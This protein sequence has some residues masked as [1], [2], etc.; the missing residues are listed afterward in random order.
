MGREAIVSLLSESHGGHAWWWMWSDAPTDGLFKAGFT[1]A[2]IPYLGAQVG[3]FPVWQLASLFDTVPGE[4][5]DPGNGDR[6]DVF[7]QYLIGF[8]D[9]KKGL[10]FT[11]NLAVNPGYYTLNSLF[12]SANNCVVK[13]VMAGAAVGIT[14]PHDVTPQNFGIDLNNMPP[15]DLLPSP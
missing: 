10:D 14:L 6:V 11:A 15:S 7:R 5:K 4:L 3:Y 13:T 9:L 8:N 2:E 12:N 1:T